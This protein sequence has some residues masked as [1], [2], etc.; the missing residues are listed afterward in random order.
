MEGIDMQR[1]SHLPISDMEKK[2]GSY[3]LH[4]HPRFVAYGVETDVP[5]LGNV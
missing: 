5:E 4:H 2:S 3:Q 1:P